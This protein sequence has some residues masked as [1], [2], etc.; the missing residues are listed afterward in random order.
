MTIQELIDT[1]RHVRVDLLTEKSKR[2][3]DNQL[4]WLVRYF[5]GDTNIAAVTPEQAAGLAK[6]LM[7]Q[8]VPRSPM[9]RDLLKNLSKC[10]AWTVARMAKQVFS[11]A[12]RRGLVSASPFAEIRLRAQKVR[13]AKTYISPEDIERVLSIVQ[14]KKVRRFVALMR[15]AGLRSSE[16]RRLQWRDVNFTDGLIRVV[17]KADADGEYR[18]RQTPISPTLRKYLLCYEQPPF[19]PDDLVC[20]GVNESNAYNTLIGKDGTGG[21]FAKAGVARF[22]RLLHSLRA[23]LVSDWQAKYPP[24]DVCSWLGHDIVISA[25]HYHQALTPS[26]RKLVSEG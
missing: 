5:G 1:Y 11:F 23:S 24:L 7:E 16:A 14:S 6:W 18:P 25:Q 22:P 9:R 4:A 15:F 20:G 21:A 17:G 10:Y 3:Q 12:T 13:G 26:I 19:P 2:T 8:Q